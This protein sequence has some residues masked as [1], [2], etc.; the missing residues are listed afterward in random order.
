MDPESVGKE[1]HT[2]DG[3]FRNPWPSFGKRQSFLA[4]FK[5]TL[6]VSWPHSLACHSHHACFASFFPGALTLQRVY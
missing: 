2:A 3:G 6:F 1:H 4:F 5:L